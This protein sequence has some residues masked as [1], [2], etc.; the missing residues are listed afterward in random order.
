MMVAACGT[1][2]STGVSID[3]SIRRMISPDT[4]ALAGIDLAAVRTTDFYKREGGRLNVPELDSLV[5]RVG[6]DPRRDISQVVAAWNGKKYFVMV[7]GH[8]SPDELER[9]LTAAGAHQTQYRKYRLIGDLSDSIAFLN[10]GLAVAGPLDVLEPAIDRF[11]DGRGG[12]PEGLQQQLD[13]VPSGDQIWLVSTGGLPF[14]ELRMRSDIESALS[15][16][17]DYINGS[18]AGVK[19]DSGFHLQAEINCVSEQGAKRVHDAL[20][21]FIGFGRLSTK[22]NE[23][24][25]LRIY[26]SIQVNQKQQTVQVRSDLT[27]DLVDALLNRFL[28]PKPSRAA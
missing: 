18:S 5:E 12:V 3:R 16:I 6:L 2:R 19:V 21:G 13:K 25:L 9:R 22:D 10:S 17:V 24:D 11:E 1:R 20:R 23:T 28:T 8:F 27:A 7:Q 4:R 15:N 26:D 14:V